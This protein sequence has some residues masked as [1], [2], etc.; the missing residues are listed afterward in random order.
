[1]I[2]IIIWKQFYIRLD[3]LAW[4]IIPTIR[5]EYTGSHREY[6][7]IHEQGRM[8]PRKSLR[9]LIIQFLCFTFFIPYWRITEVGKI[10]PKDYNLEQDPQWKDRYNRLCETEYF[11]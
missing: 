7:Q 11:N 9:H 3:L 8:C 10:Y 1:M 6:V 4:F 2:Q 5:T